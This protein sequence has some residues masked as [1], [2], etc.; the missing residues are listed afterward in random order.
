MGMAVSRYMDQHL[1][2]L[3]A[4]SIPWM[5]RIDTGDKAFNER[6]IQEL[7]ATYRRFFPQDQ[8]EP[9]LMRAADAYVGWLVQTYPN[10]P[11]Q[12]AGFETFRRAVEHFE[13]DGRLRRRRLLNGIWFSS[14]NVPPHERFTQFMKDLA[15]Y[16]ASVQFGRIEFTAVIRREMRWG[17]A[18]SP[19]LALL[20]GLEAMRHHRPWLVVAIFVV[21]LSLMRLA[22]IGALRRRWSRWKRVI[23]NITLAFGMV[24][25]VSLSSIE[26]CNPETMIC[27]RLLY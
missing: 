14:P 23:L 2:N 18:L 26:V 5:R 20:P 25:L 4:I 19:V 1:F 27:R 15:R 10:E 9:D 17:L 3:L 6:G 11:E 12:S 7:L 24:G 13:P 21:C 16:F 22:D 8:F